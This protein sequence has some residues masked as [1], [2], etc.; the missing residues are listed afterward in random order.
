MP[1]PGC[2]GVRGWPG[3][4]EQAVG[5]ESSSVFH[6]WQVQGMQSACCP[7]C[8]RASQGEAR[9]W[10]A[11]VQMFLLLSCVMSLDPGLPSVFCWLFLHGSWIRQ[12]P[13]RLHAFQ[14]LRESPYSEIHHRRF[15]WLK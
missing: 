3:D 12:R 9:L 7:L 14:E 6:V 4:W 8:L 10:G 11:A 1:P 13:S 5:S 2:N 15:D